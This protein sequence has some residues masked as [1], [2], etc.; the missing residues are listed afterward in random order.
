M[1]I[2]LLTKEYIIS[3][4]D[5]IDWPYVCRNTE[6]KIL[7]GIIKDFQDDVNWHEISKRRLTTKF[8]KENADKVDWFQI[9][10]NTS[11]YIIYKIIDEYENYLSGFEWFILLNR[12]DITIEFFKKH[13]HKTSLKQP[14]DQVTQ[15]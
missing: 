11:T 13:E 6:M 10:K 12:G 7:Y 3:H 4:A 2:E 8:I 1:D 9:C 15:N 14:R 5:S